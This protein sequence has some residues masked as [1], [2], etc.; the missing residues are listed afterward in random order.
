VP[1]SAGKAAE[2]C[3]LFGYLPVFSSA[4]EV[5]AERLAA[6]TI[7][8]I[9][10][11]MAERTRGRLDTL[12]ATAASLRSAARPHLQTLLDDSVLP[13]RP[14]AV[15]ITTADTV[16][17]G[18]LA[19]PPFGLPTPPTPS[20]RA[21]TSPCCRPWPACGPRP[22]APPPPT[23]TAAAA[24]SAPPSCGARAAPTRPPPPAPSSTACP[25]SGLPGNQTAL[26]LAAS[27]AASPALGRAGAPPLFQLVDA[28][29]AGS[30]LPR[31]PRAPP[32][33]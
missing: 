28:W 14:G 15:E 7:A 10:S 30:A 22:P 21:S 16:V 8:E 32:A 26:W 13:A 6:G 25:T 31:R 2:H 27:V 17:A 1:P 9:A 3:T 33:W 20:P 23:P 19:A 4:R 18:L 29:L 12:F 11:R 24:C 5:S